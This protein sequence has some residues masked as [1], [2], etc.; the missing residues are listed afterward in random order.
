[1]RKKV[2]AKTA[3][4]AAK[5]TGAL[6]TLDDLRQA[7]AQVLVANPSPRDRGAAY[8]AL[9]SAY[10]KANNDISRRMLAVLGE[11]VTA[12][13]TLDKRQQAAEDNLGMASARKQLG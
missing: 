2:S 9:A 6:E 4:P 12:L 3:K 13:K 8:V 5:S 1:M 7:V 10:L 11:G